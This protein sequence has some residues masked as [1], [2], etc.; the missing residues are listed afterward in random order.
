MYV[1]EKREDTERR[2]NGIRMTEMEGKEKEKGDRRDMES[3]GME[4]RKG[5]QRRKWNREKRGGRE[6]SFQMVD[7]GGKR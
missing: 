6:V 3:C 7:N 4:E 2:G 5:Q 1:G